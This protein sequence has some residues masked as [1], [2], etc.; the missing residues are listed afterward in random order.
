LELQLEIQPL[1]T[2]PRK[3]VLAEEED[4]DFG[5]LFRSYQES[6]GERVALNRHFYFFPWK[7]RY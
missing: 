2:L 6:G 5:F 1:F 4:P 3:V 7:T